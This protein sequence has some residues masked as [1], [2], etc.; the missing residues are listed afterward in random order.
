MDMVQIGGLYSIPVQKKTK[1]RK[2]IKRKEE[3][4]G[5]KIVYKRPYS[6]YF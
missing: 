1:R 6:I 5:K 3:R 4:I 2:N